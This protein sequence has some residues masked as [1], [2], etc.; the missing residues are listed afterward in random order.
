MNCIARN[1]KLVLAALLMVFAI[2][3]GCSHRE[4]ITEKNFV[5]K[6]KSSRITT[7]IYLYENGEW[8]IKTDEGGVLQY[9]VWQYKDNKIM[10]TVHIDNQIG[11]DTNP[12][13]SA[14]PREFQL[15]ENDGSVTIFSKLD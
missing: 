5:G 7:P 14:I 10:W 9:G 13:L 1:S 6:W 15:R 8:E 4:T 11:H 12:V 2:L 3:N